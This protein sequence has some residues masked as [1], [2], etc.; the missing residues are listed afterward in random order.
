MPSTLPCPNPICT[1]MFDAAAVRGAASVVCPRCG[2]KL[3]FRAPAP[4]ARPPKAPASKPRP[5]PPK[6]A[7]P[8]KPAAP[9]RPAAKPAA[10]PPA[11][12]IAKPVA[13]PPAQPPPPVAPDVAPVIRLATPVTAVEAAP[14]PGL[15]FA[16]QSDVVLRPPKRRRA[17]PGWLIAL[18]LVVGVFGGM[19]ALLF[20]AWML[21][22]GWRSP[23][24]DSSGQNEERR[25]LAQQGNFRIDPAG[26]PWE[27]DP[28]ARL[29]ADAAL[30]YR[31]SGPASFMA[32][33]FRDYKTRQPREAEL[34]DEGVNRL[35]GNMTDVEYAVQPKD[36][37]AQLGGQPGVRFE[38]QAEDRDHVPVHG[39]CVAATSRGVAYW[40]FTWAPLDDADGLRDEWA[41]LRSKFAL[42]NKR[43]GWTEKPPNLL[44]AQGD[45]LPYKLD[46]AGYDREKKKDGLWE[47]QDRDGYDPHADL[48]L[49]GYDPK[50][51]EPRSGQ[52]AAVVQVLALSSAADLTAAVKEAKDALLEIEKEKTPGGDGYLYPSAVLNDVGDKAL[53]DAG[54]DVTVGAFKGRISKF[55]AKKSADHSKYVVLA[56][57]RMDSGDALAVVCECGWERRDFWDQEFTALLAK[58]RP[59]R[60]K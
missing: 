56:V 50:D 29:G 11:L 48:V 15:A 18:F 10:K 21:P 35:R 47:K 33:A 41:G 36:D 45:K 32:L 24:D 38:F 54:P 28:K 42:E 59:A 49:L 14:P 2:T 6:A 37:K 17:L 4:A 46:Y 52:K 19:A 30:A 55:E 31:R 60:G 13:A 27:R 44:T 3:E 7:V 8:A 58:L 5:A 51:D 1:H 43:E 39:E 26:K 22:R 34:I 23:G 16:S 53:A 40:F 12:P 20:A 57:V 9:A 25:A